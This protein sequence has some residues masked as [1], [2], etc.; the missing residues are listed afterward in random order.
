MANDYTRVASMSDI[1]D[2]EMIAV[3][4]SDGSEVL[5]TRIGD[6]I[7]AVSNICSHAEAWLDAG[8]LHPES[9]EIECPLHEGR[10]DLRTGAVT[11]DPPDEPIKA[12]PVRIE[13]DDILVAPA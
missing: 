10:F 2:G 1:A 13:G 6:Q 7:H 3:R 11:H 12:Y 4:I 5:L 8:W 9:L